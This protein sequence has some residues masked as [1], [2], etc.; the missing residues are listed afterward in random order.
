[1]GRGQLEDRKSET[2]EEIEFGGRK[3]KIPFEER[4]CVCGCGVRRMDDGE[5]MAGGGLVDGE[6]GPGPWLHSGKRCNHRLQDR[7]RLVRGRL[8]N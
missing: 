3:K 4:M 1:M 7:V 8:I 2:R 6:C 5:R